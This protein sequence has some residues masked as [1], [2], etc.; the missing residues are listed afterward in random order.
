MAFVCLST[1]RGLF[2]ATNGPA[3]KAQILIR[4]Q[5][6]ID[7]KSFA[8]LDM[9]RVFDFFVRSQN[10]QDSI[11]RIKNAA[12]AEAGRRAKKIEQLKNRLDLETK[13]DV[14]DLDGTVKKRINNL[15]EELSFLESDLATFLAEK[16]ND[17]LVQENLISKNLIRNI[18]EQTKR[19]ALAEKYYL[20]IDK[21]EQVRYLQPKFDITEKVIRALDRE[22]LNLKAP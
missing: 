6:S 1:G 21:S 14:P 19:I 7:D 17:L 12:T 9:K 3:A 10:Y 18:Y 2:A 13:N 4:T 15:S 20:V 11:D 16:Q 22:S 8:M 5:S